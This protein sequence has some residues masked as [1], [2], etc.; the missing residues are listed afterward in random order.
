M[1]WRISC[2]KFTVGV[3]TD[4]DGKII[5]G[6]PIIQ[7]FK[8]QSVIDIKKWAEKKFGEVKIECLREKE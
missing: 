5:S 6:P 4:N 7:S 8:G 1:F 2:K 3:C